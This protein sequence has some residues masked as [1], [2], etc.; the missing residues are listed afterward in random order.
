[1]PWKALSSTLV[2]WLLARSNLRSCGRSTK[3]RAGSTDSLLSLRSSSVVDTGMSDGI[4][5]SCWEEQLTTVPT[6]M[7]LYH[8]KAI[9]NKLETLG[10]L[11]Q[12]SSGIL[13]QAIKL[14]LI[15]QY[16]MSSVMRM[17]KCFLNSYFVDSQLTGIWRRIIDSYY[18]LQQV[19]NTMFRWS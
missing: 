15:V 19:S 6:T 17:P 2:I 18:Q 8:T 5:V 4:S 10:K 9:Y 11:K 12:F 14:P 1:M 16:R 13:H 3:A 7:L